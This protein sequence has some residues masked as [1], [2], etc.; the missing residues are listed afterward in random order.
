MYN[1]FVG[2][3]VF[4][5]YRPVDPGSS[6]P[7]SEM[8]VTVKEELITPV[9]PE[10]NICPIEIKQ[11]ITNDTEETP[12]NVETEEQ[13]VQLEMIDKVKDDSKYICITCK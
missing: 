1:N 6:V 7:S 8:P 4:I 11:E 9:T 10:P 5:I 13:P 12:T 3:Y 2:F